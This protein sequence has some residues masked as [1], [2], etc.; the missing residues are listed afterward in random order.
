MSEAD[1]SRDGIVACLAA[2]LA[3]MGIASD[4]VRPELSLSEDL[5]LDS[6]QMMQVARH[7]ETAYAFRFS[8]ADWAL[9]EEDR[10]DQAYTISS[11]ITF[12][13]EHRPVGVSGGPA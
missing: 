3:P 11:L 12:I 6:F 10:D 2:A 9:A 1:W 5:G 13:E 4:T 8:L 7:L